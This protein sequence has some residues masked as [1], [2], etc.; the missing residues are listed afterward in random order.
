MFKRWLRRER[1]RSGNMYDGARADRITSGWTAPPS[2]FTQQTVSP[3]MLRRRA[4]DAARNSPVAARIVAI[5]EDSI[6]GAGII[7]A[8]KFPDQVLKRT[9]LRRWARFVD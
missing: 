6:I 5:H 7:P 3:E 8:V 2:D 4:R 9:V 1:T